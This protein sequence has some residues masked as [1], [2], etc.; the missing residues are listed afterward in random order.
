M[1]H[2]TDHK[3]A[4]WCEKNQQDRLVNFHLEL[5]TLETQPHLTMYVSTQDKEL[6]HLHLMVTSVFLFAILAA[7][8]IAFVVRN[9][10]SSKT[11]TI[12]TRGDHH[13]IAMNS[14]SL[15]SDE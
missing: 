11:K 8:I 9:V 15:S 2:A 12:D 6:I 5:E 3:P 10:S 1:I 14:I 4:T 7:V 13:M